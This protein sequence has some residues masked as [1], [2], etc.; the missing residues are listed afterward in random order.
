P[1]PPICAALRAKVVGVNAGVDGFVDN[2]PP[3]ATPLAAR[4]AASAR[5]AGLNRPNTASGPSAD[6]PVVVAPAELNPD[7][8]AVNVATS[9][10]PSTGS[11]T[12]VP[13]RTRGD[14]ARR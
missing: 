12:A 4:P 11:P 3:P 6:L 7:D 1:D 10:E 8:A 5:L 14:S 2:T 13:R 9:D